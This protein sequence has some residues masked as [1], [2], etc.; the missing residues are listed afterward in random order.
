MPVPQPPKFTM[1]TIAEQHAKGPPTR[2]AQDRRSRLTSEEQE[3]ILIRLRRGVSPPRI[4]RELAVGATT[5]RD[6]RRDI[7]RC[8][9]LLLSLRLFELAK[10]PD[11]KS[12]RRSWWKCLLCGTVDTGGRR[13]ALQHMLDDVYNGGPAWKR[14]PDLLSRAEAATY[15]F[16][17]RA[18][19]RLQEN[20][21]WSVSEDLL[22]SYLGP[23]RDGLPWT[24]TSER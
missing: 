2:S 15:R 16:M 1:Q 20:P 11:G 3:Y 18:P 14:N 21:L 8:P 4:A 24:P 5:V 13:R 10:A 23:R 9:S 19:R 7:G 22:E 6:E 17:R 12:S